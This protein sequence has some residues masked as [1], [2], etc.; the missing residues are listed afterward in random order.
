MLRSLRRLIHIVGMQLIDRRRFRV[1]SRSRFNETLAAALEDPHFF[2]IQIGAHDGVRF[3]DLYGKVTA[4]NAHGIVIEPLPHYFARLQMNY[5]DYP[6]IIAINVAVHPTATQLTLHHVSP[7]A[8]ASG[9]LPPWAGGI[10]SASPLHHL[11][12]GIPAEAMTTTTVPCTTLR[13]I[14]AQHAVSRID[15]LQIDTEGFDL[16]VLEM[17]PFDLVHP[18]LIKFEHVSLTPEARARARRLLESRG[19]DVWSEGEDTI[20]GKPDAWPSRR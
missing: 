11:P 9:R 12:L 1:V 4:V 3:D 13:Q 10:G 7:V 15:L 5:E 6:G 17:I 8:I 2:F 19:Y 14:V 18:R 20:A 16:E